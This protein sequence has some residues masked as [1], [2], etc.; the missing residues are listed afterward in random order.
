M[1]RVWPRHGYRGRPFN[2]SLGCTRSIVAQYEIPPAIVERDGP[3]SEFK[4]N[5]SI[6]SVEL[7]DGCTVDQVLLIAPNEV[8]AVRDNDHMPFNPAQVVRVFQTP[9][10][11]ETRTTSDWVF[12]GKRNAT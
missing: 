9:R 7:A 12:F 6:V 3:F 4:Q 1:G 5:A 10:D 2:R 11:L 8:W